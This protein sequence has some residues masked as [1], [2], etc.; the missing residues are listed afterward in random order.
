M[1]S[2]SVAIGSSLRAFGLA[3]PSAILSIQNSASQ[4]RG[5]HRR[6]RKRPWQTSISIGRCF[7]PAGPRR[8]ASR[9]TTALITAVVAG[10]PAGRRRRAPRIGLPGMANVHSHA[11]Q[12]AMAGLTEVRGP[13][14]D[15]FWTW[16]E[17]MYRFVGT[18][19]RPTMSRRWR[20][21]FT[22]R[23]WRRVSRGSASF[24]ISITT[25]MAALRQS[26]RNGG[27]HCRGRGA[28]DIG[29]TLLPMFYAH[30]DFGGADP[31]PGQRRFVCDRA[32]FARSVE[33]AGRQSR[34]L[35]AAGSASRRIRCAP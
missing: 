13:I 26:G 31:L 9:S 29:L 7:R 15:T 32:G 21:S 3:W 27:A 10:R 18:H 22:S 6:S 12:R 4:P 2:T 23:C 20:R 35:P 33:A 30:A 5:A 34:V 28:A 19:D 24:I 14:G 16:R 17:A 11:F 8:Y 1:R 25:A